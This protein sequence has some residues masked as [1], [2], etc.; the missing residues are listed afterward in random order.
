LEVNGNIKLGDFLYSGG[1]LTIQSGTGANIYLDAGAGT[2]EVTILNTGNVGIGTN[3]PGT[4]KLNV[5]GQIYQSTF[6]AP[7]SDPMCWDGVG[8]SLIGDC[9]S[10]EEYKENI[11]EYNRGLN[12]LMKLNPVRYDWINGSKQNVGFIAEEVEQ[13][14]PSL[15][16]YR[17][18]NLT[19]YQEFGM[20]GLIVNAVQEQQGQIGNL[21][22]RINNSLFKI[23]LTTIELNNTNQ[24][25]LELQ[26]KLNKLE[27]KFEDSVSFN[28]N[29]E[30]GISDNFLDEEIEEKISNL[31]NENLMMKKELCKKDNSYSWCNDLNK[32]KEGS[33]TLFLKMKNVLLNVVNFADS[34]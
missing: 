11:E 10:L 5:S 21:D 19:G 8:G 33:K 26:E 9:S 1:H 7:G 24:D 29:D 18:G 23:N 34:V 20:S 14:V 4:A 13:S 27:D 30:T 12:E 15:A 3:S 6:T 28:K 17:E 22:L 16:K 25:V 31:E 2:D 32:N